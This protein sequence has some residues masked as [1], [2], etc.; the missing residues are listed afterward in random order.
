MSRKIA[1]A[2]ALI[3]VAAFVW[4]GL[5]M[6]S[7]AVTESSVR[8][9]G[10]GGAG[11]AHAAPPSE[12]TPFLF[13]TLVAGTPNGSGAPVID[14]GTP[15]PVPQTGL[16][17]VIQSAYD[18]CDSIDND[19]I[20]TRCEN[21]E[22]VF[23]RKDNVG[24]RYVQY[25]DAYSDTLIELDAR[26]TVPQVTRYGV[27]FR[28]AADDSAFYIFGLTNEGQYGLFR[29]N[30]DHYE[31]LVPYTHSTAIKTGTGKNHIKIV[32][33]GDQIA[34]Y[35]NQ[36][37]LDT[38]RDP[39][40]T[41]GRVGFFVEGNEAGSEGAFDNFQVYTIQ[42]PLDLPTVKPVSTPESG[43]NVT[44]TAPAPTEAATGSPTPTPQANNPV[45][46]S[47]GSLLG[48]PSATPGSQ[49]TSALP[50]G[51][52]L[53]LDTYDQC[54][55]IQNDNIDVQCQDGELLFKKLTAQDSHW[56]FY[57]GDYSDADIQLDGRVF[58]GSGYIIYGL[59][60][61]L[62]AAGDNGYLF[63]V[64]NQGEFGVYRWARPKF[65]ALVQY[66]TKPSVATGTGTNHLRVVAQG[67]Q[68]TF[69][70]ND[71]LVGSVTD[72]NLKTGRA[73]LYLESEE[74]NVTVAFDNLTVSQ[75]AK[76][77]NVATTAPRRTTT[78]RQ[79][80]TATANEPPCKLNPGEAGLLINNSYMGQQMRFTIGGGEWKTH[81]YDIP[82]DGEWY[83]LRM[84]PGTYTYTASI[85]GAGV[86]HGEPYAYLEGKC[87]QILF[88][89]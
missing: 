70:V 22:Y 6:F 86:S 46:S 87:R 44:P 79:T 89:P 71:Q 65:T 34:L 13:S 21:G 84:P 82:G 25:P 39:N 68:F 62:D 3:I 63:G 85:P 60:F 41:T 20:F 5:G 43:G 49:A 57:E 77:S 67:S 48:E 31:T 50:P 66:T 73:A 80:P 18:S 10:L 24:T 27:V 75:V 42:Q 17:L 26:A 36:E 8:A 53:F 81:D 83:L 56:I 76:A 30:Q 15:T 45:I 47:I 19:A 55:P 59:M 7:N 58:S 12:L 72:R 74:A 69:Y 28:L 54:D 9:V 33:Q 14:L 11:I 51:N 16:T 52:V 23:K 4:T 2:M 37:F 29:F 64:S 32:N 35:V 1:R 61:R 38:V 88:K 78:A 40:L